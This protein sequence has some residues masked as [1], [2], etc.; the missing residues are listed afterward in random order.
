M[1][2]LEV[3]SERFTEIDKPTDR[4]IDCSGAAFVTSYR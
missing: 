4:S 3:L 1:T 2:L